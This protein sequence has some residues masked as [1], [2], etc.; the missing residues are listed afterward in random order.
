MGVVG[1]RVGSSVFSGRG[2]FIHVG[3][4]MGTMMS[5]NV[6]MII[7]PNQKKVIADLLAGRTPDAKYGKQAKQ[8]STHNNYLTLPVLFL[9]LLLTVFIYDK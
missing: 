7:I 3:A 8:R 5:G 6:A 9:M 4:L 1:A 2:A